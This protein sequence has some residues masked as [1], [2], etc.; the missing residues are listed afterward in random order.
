[1]GGTRNLHTTATD[2]SSMAHPLRTIVY[3]LF[4]KG[5]VIVVSVSLFI[6]MSV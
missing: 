1:M 2:S 6:K 3:S 5:G 4:D